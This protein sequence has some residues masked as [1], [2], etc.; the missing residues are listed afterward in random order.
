[1]NEERQLTLAYIDTRIET[2]KR[3]GFGEAA[4]ALGVLSGDL[5][6]EFHV[7]SPPSDQ[8]NQERQGDEIFCAKCGKRWPSNEDAP[9]RCS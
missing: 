5:Q 2:Y 1:M 4:Q 7:E 8:H 6:N 9:E 3:K